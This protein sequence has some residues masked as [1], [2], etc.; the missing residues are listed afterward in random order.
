MYSRV[1]V[2]NFCNDKILCPNVFWIKVS[3]FTIIDGYFQN[4]VYFGQCAKKYKQKQNWGEKMRLKKTLG[5]DV[6]LLH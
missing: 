3:L 4:F 2:M 1:Y 6:L 5:L